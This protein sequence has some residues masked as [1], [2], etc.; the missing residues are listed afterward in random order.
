MGPGL[1]A[2]VVLSKYVDALPIYRQARM[3]ERL[4]P[5]FTRQTMGQWVE[6][7]A[8]LFRPVYD[9]L[10]KIVQTSAYTIGDETPIR[11]LDPA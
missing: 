6:Q 10:K 7:A 8:N 5:G 9:E 4:G 11:V 3:L 2:H 1:I